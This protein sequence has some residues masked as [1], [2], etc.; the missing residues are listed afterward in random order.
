MLG[1]GS[2]DEIFVEPHLGRQGVSGPEGEVYAEDGE[3][4]LRADDAGLLGEVRL[5]QAWA[6]D[7]QIRE[8]RWMGEPERYLNGLVGA[9]G[10]FSGGRVLAVGEVG[11]LVEEDPGRSAAGGGGGLQEPEQ[12]SD[13]QGIENL[14]SSRQVRDK[15]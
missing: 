7:A 6:V 11:P 9:R 15:Y 14:A 13:L 4:L 2:V 12:R 8:N 10:G 3:V 1:V 5:L